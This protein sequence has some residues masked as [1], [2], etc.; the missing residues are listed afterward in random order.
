M[1]DPVTHRVTR[2]E[3]VDRPSELRRVNPTVPDR[4]GAGGDSGSV[5]DDRKLDR[6]TADVDD[7]DPHAKRARSSRGSPPGPRLRRGVGPN[8]QALVDHVLAESGGV[9]AQARDAVDHVHD[10]MEAVEVVE[11]DHVEGSG[12]GPLLLV[13]AHV[14][15]WMITP[16]I[17][18]AVNEPRVAVVSED[19]RSVHR[20]ERV[21]LAVG[22]PVRML[23]IRLEAHEVDHVDEAHRQVGKLATKDGEGGQGLEGGGVPAGGEHHVWVPVVVRRPFPDPQTACAMQDGIVHGQVVESGLLT[24]HDNVDVVAAAQ[25]VVHH[26]QQAIGI[27]RQ[28]DPD[29]LRLFV[30]H[31][32]DEPRVLVREAVVVLS[33]DVTRE[34]VV[35]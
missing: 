20:E 27:R 25:A 6:R 32:V 19:D 7:E 29:H 35:E 31:V 28:V 5:R 1:H 13:A 12:G 14:Q 30:D 34:E 18:K 9:R 33:P 16:A 8:A 26:R 4:H 15:I 21:E 17:C 3:D 11:H 24:G 22:E 10:Q 23:R 2:P